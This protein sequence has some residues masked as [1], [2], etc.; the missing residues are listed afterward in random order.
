MNVSRRDM[1]RLGLGATAA[2]AAG[3]LPA[4]QQPQNVAWPPTLR[5]AR[6]GTVTVTSQRFLD[7]PD[8][9]A[10][11]RNQ[12]GVAPFVMA[13]TA[14]TVDLAFHGQLGENAVTRRLWSSWG[15]I[16]L[17]QNGQVYCAIGD[18]GDD[19]G[20][21]ARCFLYRWNPQQ[22]TLTQVVN[23]NQVIPPREGQPAWSKVHAKI[24]EGSDGKIYFS[25]TL[26]DGNR[27]H[28]DNYHWTRQLPG[29]QL[30][31]LDPQNNRVSVITDLPNGRCT[32]T[33][34]LDRQRNIWWC[35][36]EVGGNAIWGYDLANRR[37][38]FRGE[39]GSVAFN[40]NFALARDG[41]IYFNGEEGRIMKVDG[42]TRQVSRT[43]SAFMGT[44]GMRSSTLQA[45]NGWIYGT[46]HRAR[47][48]A[49]SGQLFRYHPGMNQLAMLGPAWMREDYV[50][51]TALSPDERY[52]YYLPG[53]H[54]GAFRNGTP[55]IQYDIANNRRKVLA[56]LA[57]VFE[58]EHAYLPA[59]TYGM[60]VSA[61]G[62]TIFV[63]FNGHAAD[64]IRPD[65]MRP[66]GFGLTS[67]AAIHIPRSERG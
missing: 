11:M 16:C 27:A 60:K 15:D 55:V 61:D 44:P 29:G 21:D 24:D 62:S 65:N 48:S 35:N 34:I 18:H 17:T 58:R 1:L 26:N 59:G 56:F 8:S 5:N 53:A 41:S 66:N 52:V 40:R 51:V 42:R 9:V 46:T 23:M 32:A 57:P 67:F 36:L 64:R 45:R 20:G 31:Q 30:Y 22:K 10:M 63:N 7:I 39:D 2:L 13:E 37:Q 6:N 19:A 14:P 49:Q 25:C 50:T 12:E 47:N 54:G 28:N 3:R 43:N 38:V 33:S 4:Q